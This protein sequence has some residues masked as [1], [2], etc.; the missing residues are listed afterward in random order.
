MPQSVYPPATLLALLLTLGSAPASALTLE[1]AID[2]ALKHA[3]QVVVAKQDV[4][5]VEADHMAAL[6]AIL[7]RLDLSAS[8][9]GFLV[10][11]SQA[12]NQM[13]VAPDQPFVGGNGTFSQARFSVG[14]SGRQLLYDGGRWWTV[15]ARVSDVEES[16]KAALRNV[17]NEVRA[18]TVKAFYDLGKADYA[19]R[20][21]EERVKLSQEQLDRAETLIEVGRG[22]TRDVATAARNLATDQIERENR[23]LERDLAVQA[24][25]LQMGR[26]SQTA[27]ELVLDEAATSSIVTFD[28]PSRETLVQSALDHRPDLDQRRAD[29]A[30]ATKDIDVAKADYWPV[31]A[32]QASYQRNNPQPAV[33]F[34]NPIE[35]YVAALD[36]VVRWNLFEGNA[37]DARVAQARVALK[38]LLA[39]LDDS[40]RRAVGNVDA[41]LMRLE[42]QRR[43]HDLSK[44]G[45]QAAE[46]AVRLARGLYDAGRGTALELRDAETSLTDARRTMVSARYDIEVTRE[47][48]RR[49]VG[50]DLEEVR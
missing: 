41:E 23:I 20:T 33:T 36:L 8:A 39:N 4:V 38:K 11:V 42:N 34:G 22:T 30:V 21:I 27:V 6:S 49:A 50:I 35:N 47:N 26:P 2:H 32:V 16:R 40:V 14:L 43:I 19:V 7:P 48:L 25:N 3:A 5:L 10:N 9:G 13:V 12:G 44:R 46:E 31:V 17:E 15:I 37:T 18:L 24:L 28:L 29:L 1:D 45:V